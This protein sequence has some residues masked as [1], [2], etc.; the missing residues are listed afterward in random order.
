M[1]NHEIGECKVRVSHEWYFAEMKKKKHFDIILRGMNEG[2]ND[3]CILE[4]MQFLDLIDLLYMANF[5][6]RFRVLAS[7]RSKF[8]VHPSVIMRRIG[9]MTLRYALSTLRNAVANLIISMDSIQPDSF[10]TFHSFSLKSALAYCIQEYT[11]PKLKVVS[12]EKFENEESRTLVRYLLTKFQCR[13]VQM[14][15]PD[16]AVKSNFSAFDG[17]HFQE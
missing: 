1:E 3:D 8:E 10:S 4:I 14:I 13:G 7:R 9:L 6:P 2:L 17:I 5:N 16:S 15:L 11:G 12:L